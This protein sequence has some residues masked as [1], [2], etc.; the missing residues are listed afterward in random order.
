[1]ENKTCGCSNH[2]HEH[3]CGDACAC[4]GHEH[5]HA[6]DCGCGCGGHEEEKVVYVFDPNI[7]EEQKEFLEYLGKVNALPMAKFIIMNSEETDFEVLALDRVFITDTSDTMDEI[8]ERAEFLEELEKKGM[9]VIDYDNIIEGHDYA[10]FR[11]SELYE[12]FCETVKEGSQNENFWGDTPVLDVGY[13]TLTPEAKAF[14]R[15]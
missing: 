8:Q 6:S 15:A 2:E 3:K 9:I 11:G 7:D 14:L 1:M 10:E 12:Y 4:G 13:M 5:E